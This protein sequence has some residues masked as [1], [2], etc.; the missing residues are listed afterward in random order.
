MLTDLRFA[1]RSLWRADV[2]MGSRL[3][4]GTP[5]RLA[6]LPPG[7]L[8]IDLTP[9]RQR[10]LTLAPDTAGSGSMAV[11]QNWRAALDRKR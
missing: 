11:V 3:T 4:A 5:E 6:S 9:D 7:I 10:V 2:I 8:S 1:L